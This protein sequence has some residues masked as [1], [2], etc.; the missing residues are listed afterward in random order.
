MLYLCCLSPVHNRLQIQVEASPQQAQERN[1]VVTEAPTSA[2]SASGASAVRISVGA[3]TGR[4]G[5]AASVQQAPSRYTRSEGME[6]A[7]A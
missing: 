1:A 3:E 4:S 6:R 7:R 5:M 2:S